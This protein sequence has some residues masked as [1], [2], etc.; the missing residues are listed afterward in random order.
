MTEQRI[1]FS[2]I[3]QNQL[4]SYVKEEF[5]LISEFLK[6]YYLAQE[7]QGGPVDLIQNIDRYIKLNESTSTIDSVILESDV[8]VFA[9]TI[10][11]DIIKSPSGTNGFPESY[12]LLK[13]GD[14]IITYSGK[15]SRSFTG[16]IRGFSGT[17]SLKKDAKPDE[18]V[19]DS[20]L[21]QAHTAGDSIQNLSVLFLKEF[22]VKT[23]KQF[24][25]GLSDR[26]LA[27]NL[28]QNLFIKQ[29]KDF[30]STRGTD[31][32][33]EILFK[34][35]YDED[36]KVVRPREFLLTPSNAQYEIVRNFVVEPIEG[37]P[38]DLINST[39]NQDSYGNTITKA[40]AP[41]TDAEKVITGLGQTYYKL[42]I[43]AGYDRDIVVDGAVYGEF[44]IHPKTKIIGAVS[45]G[46]TILDVDSTVGFPTGGELY[47]TYNDAS[48]GIVSYTSKS[49]NQFYGC[50]NITGRILDKTEV[51]INTYAY[52][53]SSV[54]PDKI[55][56]VR[57][58]PVIGSFD[59]PVDT[60]YYQP[61]DTVKIKT[62]GSGSSTF[63][64]KNWILNI[65]PIFG[66]KSLTLISISDR[67]YRVTL[68]KDHPFKLGDSAV[69]IGSD[70]STKTTKITEIVSS[71]TFVI[72]GQGDLNL[73][74]TYKI[75]KSLQRAFSSTFPKISSYS[76]N[77][78]NIYNDKQKLLVASNSLPFYD[79]QPLETTDRSITFSGT[80][81]AVGVGSTDI[82]AITSSTDHGF[83][84]GDAVYY[85]PQKVSYT[86]RNLVGVSSTGLKVS[87]SLISD[88]IEYVV[89]GTINNDSEE[90]FNRKPPG[91]GLYFVKRISSSQ[92]KLAKSLN[93]IYDRKFISVTD[94]TTVTDNILQV[95][96]LKYKELKPQKIFREISPPIYDAI[97]HET[98]PGYTGVLIN[99]VEIKN[100]K[101][102]DKVYYGKID[103]IEVLSPGANFDIINPPY[104][105]I[106]D[107]VG[108]AATGYVALSG[109]LS[110]IRI[111]N[112][113][114][115]YVESPT[116]KITGG[117][118]IGAIATPNL[119]LIE[120][121]A[122]FNSEDTS[123]TVGI[124]TLANTIGF[125]T[126]HKFR[127]AEQVIYY[128]GNQRAVGGLTTYSAYYVSVQDN[129]VIKL[130][131]SLGDA[132]SGINT[133][134]ITSTG[135]GKHSFRAVN[136]KQVLESINIVSSGSGYQNKKRTTD[137]AGV[138]T[139]YDQIT[140]SNHDYNSGEIVRYTSVGTAIGGLTSGSDYYITKVDDNTFKLSSVGVG[141]TS[142]DF[143]Y[144]TKQYV[145][146]TSVG[147]GTHT[148]NYQPIEVTISG[149][150]GIS[151]IATETFQATVQPIF[152][153]QVT[154]VHL[155]NKGV[156]YGSSEIINLDRQPEI[157]LAYGKNAQVSPVVS[158]GKIV[159]VIV[160]NS[161]S[162]Y[163]SPPDLIISG[164]GVGAVLTPVISNGSITEVKVI[165][166]GDGY[167]QSGTTVSVIV[168]GTGS[169]KFRAKLQ[170][171][172]VNLVGRNINYFRGDDGFISEGINP[173]YELQ[174]SHLYAPR[175]LREIVYAVDSNGKTLY[176]QKDLI[177]INNVEQNSTNHSPIIGWS[178]D[179]HPIY[180]PYGY[181]TR[182]GGV[183][184]QMKS[185]YKLDLKSN[186]PTVTE[187]P[188]GFFVE[189]YTYLKV[190]DESTLDE[191]NGR[192][193]VTPEYPKG[194]YAYFAT[195]DLSV[196]SAGPFVGYKSPAFPY[197]VG[198]NFKG[199]PNKF[200]FDFKSNQDNVDLNKT[201]WS[202]NTSAYNLIDGSVT[203]EYVTIPN[204]LNQTL[205]VTA[206]TPGVVESIG[207]VTGGN[208]YRVND[209]VVF[210]NTGTQGSS[211]IAKVSKIGG[212]LVNS[213]SVAT[214]TITDVEI[215]PSDT[216][217]NYTVICD[218]PH[219]FKDGDFVTITGLST[220]SSKIEGSYQIGVT[221]NTLAI[222]GV[223]TSST[224]I[225]TLSATGIVTY[226]K[227]SGNLGLSQ[228]R[229][230]DILGIGTEKVKVLN[231]EPEFSRIRVLRSIDGTIGSSHTVTTVLY[232]NSRKFTINSGFKTTYDYKVNKEIYFNP[233]ES[234]GVG[235]TFGVGIGYTLTISNPG[236]GLTIFVPTRSIF[237]KNHGL[238]TGDQLIYSPNDGSGLVILEN[239]V[240][241]GTTLRNQQSVFVAKISNNLI[242]LS[243]VR[244]GLGTTG[245]FVGIAST[246]SN[247]TLMAFSGIGTGT[248][249]SFTTNYS[250]ITG[251]AIRRLVTVSTAQTHGLESNHYV[252]LTV[253]PSIST[254]FVIKYNDYNRKLVVNPKSF[255]SSGINTL[256]NSITIVNHGYQTGNKV[257]H[258]TTGSDQTLENNKV[259][260]VVKI[261]D[262]TIK[263]SNTYYE[264]TSEKPSIVGVAST[265]GTLSQINPPI[266]VYGR[267]SLVFDVSDSSLAYS[268]QST[269]Y[270][271]FDLNFYLDEDF[272]EPF[273]KDKDKT[274]FNVSK[275]GRIG[276]DTS[277]T[278]TLN[279]TSDTPKNLFYKLD[280]VFESDLP[281]TKSEINVDSSVLSNNSISI[282]NSLYN[283]NH[284][285]S[286]ASTN[287][288]TFTIS[289]QPESSSY[290]SST[291]SL[292]YTTNCTHAYGP[293][294]EV[295]LED[296]GKNYYVLPGI[297]T[298]SPASGI[299]TG[300]GTG[301]VLEA[302]SKSIGRISRTKIND[303]G[304]DFPSDKTLRPSA[305]L[306]Q[307][308]KIDLLTSLRSVGISSVGRGYNTAPKLLLFDGKTNQLMREVD[309]RYTLGKSNV[310][311]LKNTYGIT[312]TTP[313]ILPVNN[314]NGVGISTVGFNTITKD[315]TVTL[316]VGFSTA[317][318]FPFTVGD[319]VLIENISVGIGSTAKGYNS[320]NYDYSL[321]TLTAVDENR[322]GIGTVTYNLTNYLLTGENPGIFDSRNSSGRIIP[323]KHF[324]TFNVQL[325]PNN[326]IVGETV[327]SNSSS[328]TVEGWNSQTGILRISSNKDF[329][330]NE[331]ITGSTSR[332]QGIASSITT[333]ESHF[334]LESTS[335][336]VSGWKNNSGFLNDNLQRVQDSLY[337]Q[338]FS[339]SIRSRVDYETWN[340]AVSAL[341]HTSGFKKFSDYQFESSSRNSMTVGISTD[342]TNVDVVLDLTEIVNLNCVFDFD[343]ATENSLTQGSTIV[344]DEII[345][346]SRVLT[347]FSESIGN[348]VLS[349]D[350]VSGTFNSNPR[351]TRFSIVN[352]FK[353]SEN[354][355]QKY[356]A[357]IR[358]RRFTSQRQLMVVTLIHDGSFGYISQYG[359][360]ESVYDLGSFDFSISGTDGQLAFYPTK[361]S[362]ND[363][364]LS[365][366]SYNLDDNL[367]GVGSTGIGGI[368]DIKTTSK[369][370]VG[371]ASTS[372][373][374]IGSTYRSVKVL[375]EITGSN[376]EYE[377]DELN[378]IHDGSEVHFTDYGQLTTNPG[379]FGIPGF[380]TY[381]PYISGS[382]LI[383]D[384]IPNAGVA[385]TINTIQVAISSEGISGIGTVDLKH[386]RLE[387]RSTLISSSGSPG[388]HTIG[389]YPN[390]YDSAY[391]IVQVTD[392]TN[393]K[394]QMSE[395]MVVDSFVDSTTSYDVFD[396]EFGVV[397]TS[398]GLGTI[399]SRVSIAGT[400]E[401]TFTPNPSIAA[402]VKV[403][404]N[405]LK[406]QDDAKQEI[407][408][409][410]GTI[411]TGF[412]A[413]EGTDS[414]ILRSFQ[415]EHRTNPIF[416]KEFI[417]SA[418]TVVNVDNNTIK[419]PN[420]FFVSGE[421]V[422]YIHAGAGSTQAIG[423][424]TTTFSGIG[425]TDKLPENVFIIK[426]NDDTIKL[427]SS[428]ENALKVVPDALD[429]TSVGIGTSHRFIAK[430]QNT[431]AL[432]ALDNIIQSPV[433][434]TAI[435][436]ILVD[437]V[438]TTDDLIK[439]SGIT[440]F[441]G[442]D[443]IKINNEIMKIEGVGIGSTNRIRVR[444]GWLGTPLV[445][446]ST[447]DLVTKVTG[448]Y[449][450]VENTLTFTEA[451]YGNTPLGTSTNA[452]DERDWTGISTGSSFQGRIFLRTAGAGTTFEPYHNNYVFDDI[453]YGFDGSS[454]NF[455]LKSN[456]S[457]VTGIATENAIILIND[458][459]QGPGISN[460]YTL[461]QT[462]GITSIRFTGTATSTSTDPNTTNLPLGGV[463]I[464][465]GSTEGFGYQPLV[466]AGGTAIVSTSGT[467]QS[468]SVG[469][470][471]SG[472]RA[473]ST[474]EILTETS[475]T[476]GIGSTVIHLVNQN[477]VFSL[478]NLL[479]VGSTCTIGIGTTIPA[480]IV[481]VG[482]TFVRIG[483]ANTVSYS[484]ASGT[485]V[486]VKIY[487]PQVGIV[488]VGVATS[489]VGITSIVHVG[490]A[491]I[492]SGNISTTVSITN[493]G[494]G[495]TSTGISPTVIFD[496]PL[497]Y[498]NIP[499][500]YSSSSTAGVGTAATID[501]IVGQG[502]SVIDFEI[503]KTGYA[504]GNGQV[505]T[506]PTGGLTG[507]PTDKSKPFSEFQV[508]VQN[509]F[510][511]EFTGWSLGTLEVLDNIEDQ[512][513]GSTKA[514]ELRRSGSLISIRSA[515]GSKINVQD[516]LLVFINDILQ[517]PGRGYTFTGGSILT[518]TE[519]PKGPTSDGNFGG[520]KCKILFY[521][522]TGNIDVVD[523]EIIET[524]KVG[525]EL[526][527]G[528][529]SYLDQNENLQ[530]NPRTVTSV[531]STDIV[532]TL[533]YL[534]PGNTENESLLRPV[535]WCR[536]TEDKIINEKEI[537]KDRE[538]YEPVINPVAYIIQSVGIGSTD[539]YVDNIRPFFNPQNENNISLNFQKKVKFTS[540][541]IKISAAASAVVSGLG[542]ITSIAISTGGIGYNTATVSIG[543]TLQ[544]IGLGTTATANAII[545]AGGTISSINIT[546]AGT[547]YTTT[548]P[549]IILISSP[550]SV[551]EENDVDT[552]TG[553]QGVVVGFGTTTIS[554]QTKLRF[555]LHIPLDSYLRSSTYMGVSGVTTISGISTGDYLMIFNT[556]VGSAVTSL[557]SSGST[558]GVGTSFVDNIY[559]VDDYQIVQSP[560]GISS[561]GVGIGTSH[562][563]R[564]FVRVSDNFNYTG[565]TTSG[566][567]GEFSWG[568]IRLTSR[569]GINS[570]SA[571]TT[572]GVT[573]IKTSMMISRSKSLK[574]KNYLN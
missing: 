394:Y 498:S 180:G 495:Y 146:F 76:A 335:K 470:T 455:I 405:A 333:F 570:Y 145:N 361:Y 138:S 506:I 379:F 433:V 472:Y 353:L 220:T 354:R 216:K 265:A 452:P 71:D 168:P 62:L 73:S 64:S 120:H 350:D 28:N 55:V 109:S 132:I 239:S 19:F 400:V 328:G 242:G 24:L 212:K 279:I 363:Y 223:G 389:S 548:N 292:N 391:F 366:I 494:S 231:V 100:Y 90:V 359:R 557:T 156:G 398:S 29:A 152:R 444:R 397:E 559:Y 208:N 370:A 15:T 246:V 222:V 227:V 22:L 573:G 135:I 550:I 510:T 44:S 344:S 435:T 513:D 384:F 365:V 235:T 153:G 69:I 115:D 34:A 167:T 479:S 310:E 244:V 266:N 425:N 346:S 554:S 232:E 7:Y 512:F 336:V 396:T 13:I 243:T 423:I 225:G 164:S 75:K 416:V 215:Y 445:G 560:T 50:S 171:W 352:T 165:E 209:D 383:V 234:V 421:S 303:I 114:F 198:K 105:H 458:V 258:T 522:G 349:I 210:N 536:Q 16:C 52:G 386:A 252:D 238:E 297:T 486:S 430:N 31:R 348:R 191:N 271:A 287:S 549:P 147:V 112:P 467:I 392:T 493:A 360:V 172:T 540:Q 104:L 264:S 294:T 543:N 329:K 128:T 176:G 267:S 228:I 415:L 485:P 475:Q 545:S 53:Y 125:T 298:I 331:V 330:K 240:G 96:T 197:L 373:V 502:S 151:S 188:V 94:Q 5:P 260:F 111:L 117:N 473:A 552:Y 390:D 456:G 81:P 427:A 318:T 102:T 334:N 342:V 535:V 442:A 357:Y 3:V 110:E 236:A 214:S 25:P 301:A 92:I 401:L 340:D 489:S 520:D 18:V 199:I 66:V 88:D 324:P 351:P 80:F 56:K 83:Y 556:N 325:Q 161:G 178:Y 87:S 10:S 446:H 483:T 332:T 254:T 249:H 422:Q 275:N 562:V 412:G 26:S 276:I 309:L 319:K 241:I 434:S 139:S 541:D 36:A 158:N 170:S 33:F 181:T 547:G 322:G 196:A 438:F 314:S 532:S 447:G 518:F 268:N 375:V 572:N 38:M 345:F 323:Q 503:Q 341:N 256:T 355:A 131:K 79:G 313:T 217:G 35:L 376:N 206:I 289:Q 471:G 134:D 393:N 457:D 230:N 492:I 269:S 51:G 233:T 509:T 123:S 364:N 481:S 98:E 409:N 6:Q 505:L 68:T 103:E 544:S 311:I 571:Y 563:K 182:S 163:L 300:T 219:N 317:N 283:G 97:L 450:I 149:K 362:V 466:S 169:A 380:G 436:T 218:N 195:F 141:T 293:I 213:V 426:I 184:T 367:L 205:D 281:I 108:T 523:K 566:Y 515:R 321:F 175:K 555:D 280:P 262:D 490:Y 255:I 192:F 553:D 537:S 567:F 302:S 368:I 224:G 285:V 101:S 278:V 382:N 84:T 82:F 339:Y 320:E 60:F 288:F 569:T 428:S 140:I 204:K 408:F 395:V 179:G 157:T 89:T 538:L 74:L 514:F 482:T 8:D 307:I 257:I 499:L 136:K 54:S 521:K 124:S 347:D 296:K 207:I 388:I 565:V 226:F 454:R 143:Y 338:N 484:I 119:K 47:V 65:S 203:Y 403:Y 448:N 488:N 174:Y 49:I 530:E 299:S 148:F 517:V 504:Y 295:K 200:N 356:F 99:G 2:N 561:D 527:L 460:D 166:T 451:P 70:E 118:G 564:I 45:L 308:A 431:K 508:T 500:I 86:Y 519:A 211:A 406:L 72:K 542:S 27:E 524:V 127:N 261:D 270:S 11:V 306:P 526:T 453:S 272:T 399:G 284:K 190:K 402:D 439:F 459:F 437:Q 315:V 106:A 418:S 465:V 23:K 37:D 432:I 95:Y 377:F 32:S 39:L 429:I 449:N 404:M 574:F 4:P 496:N 113:G 417:G 229:E 424:A 440:S 477:S 277:A 162:G 501:I 469:N 122:I 316:A 237:I 77:V 516:V 130:H 9:T 247:A 539:I 59:Y 305:L 478:L 173:G 533:P 48:S 468:I 43:D 248:R 30:Y 312:N 159:E 58:R 251:K 441:F 372:I 12:G 107:R 327:T 371:L 326:Y 529:D 40:Y 385:A 116:I 443:L 411:R 407:N 462:T 185:G 381:N 358:D 374:S 487:N 491:T 177:K 291:S 21:A 41:I 17:S 290:I 378:I 420:H 20:T 464:S 1:K 476:V 93:N 463:I 528:Y 137:I 480:N 387:G 78:Q 160:L 568:K 155:E 497:S 274:S 253:N 154:S 129:Q 133:V 221:T 546:N 263:L 91:E 126:Y 187:F 461:T 474:Y 525:D 183:A 419:L 250:V 42:G 193:C 245:T 369:N 304:L 121:S 410:N 507:I 286:V 61:E 551:D 142:D 273:Y 201:N 63:E 14:E 186:R 531:N 57:L 511:D 144:Q 189:D 85:I 534:G 414:D 46:S 202:R 67:T 150:I 337:Y 413:Y 194:T 343:L 558:V 282:K 259:Y